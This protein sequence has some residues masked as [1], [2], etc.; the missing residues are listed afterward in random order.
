[1]LMQPASPLLLDTQWYDLTASVST[2]IDLD[3]TA[4]TSGALV[5]RRGVRSAAMLLRLTL[6]YGPGDLSLHAAAA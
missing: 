6:A 3:A 1:M 2:A 5:R 4:R